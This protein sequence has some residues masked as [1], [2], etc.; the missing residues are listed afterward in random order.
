MR[1]LRVDTGRGQCRFEELPADK[2]LLGNRGL[3]AA[4]ARE[5]IDPVC[6]PLGPANK[7]I[8]AI[9]PLAGTPVSSSARISVGGKSPLTGGIKEANGGGEV[10]RALASLGIRAVILEDL[11]PAAVSSPAAATVGEKTGRDHWRVLVLSEEGAHLEE[12][13]A[14]AGK[15]TYETAA[16]LRGWYGEKAAVLC[17]GPAGEMRLPIAGVFATDPD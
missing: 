15:G 13:E 17:I 8:I 4:L 5:E 9:G 7:L 3:I 10:G 2:V 14:L 12:A 6:H 16:L 1:W 11:P